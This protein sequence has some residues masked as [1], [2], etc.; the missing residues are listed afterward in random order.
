VIKRMAELS[1][2]PSDSSDVF[3]K[4][5]HEKYM[6]RGVHLEDV[7]MADVFCTFTFKGIALPNSRAL[8]SL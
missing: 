4:S 3:E 5:M 7:C 1:K 6:R 8:G 2:L